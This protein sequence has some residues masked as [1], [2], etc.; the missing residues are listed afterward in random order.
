MFVIYLYYLC[1]LSLFDICVYWN[2]LYWLSQRFRLLAHSVGC[3]LLSPTFSPTCFFHWVLLSCYP[4]FFRLLAF[5]IGC[6]LL[7][8][9][10]FFAYLLVPLGAS[11]LLSPTFPPTCFFHW[12]SLAK[13]PQLFRPLASF[14]GHPL[15][16]FPNF[17]AHLL[18]PLGILR[19]APP[20]PMQVCRCLAPR[21]L[22]SCLLRAPCSYPLSLRIKSFCASKLAKALMQDS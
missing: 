7:A 12:V 11:C 21:S 13:L 3:F 17:F 2:A 5:S 16:N 18:F 20:T 22:L 19:R 10:N 9:P 6:F 8:F 15:Q 14:I 4:Q 1:L